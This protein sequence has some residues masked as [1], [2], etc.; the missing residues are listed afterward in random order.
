MHAVSCLCVVDHCA[1]DDIEAVGGAV[2]PG[3]GRGNPVTLSSGNQRPGLDRD[4]GI[5]GETGEVKRA[6]AGLRYHWRRQMLLAEYAY[7]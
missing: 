2:L 6:A 3:A 4:T 5:A 1:L 7:R